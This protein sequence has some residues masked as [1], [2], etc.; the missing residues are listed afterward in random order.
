MQAKLE[1]ILSKENC[2]EHFTRYH[3]KFN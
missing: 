2:I 1:T 3:K